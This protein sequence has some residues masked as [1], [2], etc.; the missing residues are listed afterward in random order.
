MTRIRE[1]NHRW[2]ASSV[3][4]QPGSVYDLQLST[5]YF[6]PPRAERS[7][8]FRKREI[9]I[10]QRKVRFSTALLATH[11]TLQRPS[12]PP[13]P[14]SRVQLREPPPPRRATH[15][16]KGATRYQNAKCKWSSAHPE[17]GACL[18]RQ[19]LEEAQ[20][21][22]FCFESEQVLL[23]ATHLAAGQKSEQLRQSPSATKWGQR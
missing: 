8:G 13:F 6:A 14:P 15:P 17:K 2:L 16:T 12:S 20:M 9:R 22:A 11:F 18:T 23:C 21:L 7:S 10:A 4:P 1:S 19:P 5:F 3:Y